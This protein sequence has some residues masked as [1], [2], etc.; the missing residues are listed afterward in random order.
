MSPKNNTCFITTNVSLIVGLCLWMLAGYNHK[1][2]YRLFTNVKCKQGSHHCYLRG[3][4]KQSLPIVKREP[5]SH[6][7]PYY[8]RSWYTVGLVLFRYISWPISS[9]LFIIT[10][11]LVPKKKN[12]TRSTTM[13]FVSHN[14]INE[15]ES[16]RIP[17]R[18]SA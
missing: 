2:A 4:T 8:F 3:K 9:D 11:I 17:T 6:Y 7:F 18:L 15:K 5:R 14:M 16:S 13:V 12:Y 1:R 10:D